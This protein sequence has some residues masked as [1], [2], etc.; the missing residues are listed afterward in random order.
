[1]PPA[2]AVTS[3]TCPSR[4]QGAAVR[5]GAVWGVWAGGPLGGAYPQGRS[6]SPQA[7]PDNAA[8]REVESLPAVC[9]SEGCTW[10]GTLKEYE[11]GPPV[12][13]SLPGARSLPTCWCWRV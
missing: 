1:M 13:H 3:G 10:K 11:V 8:R 2:A 6:L 9:P 7:F 5:E 12:R 4:R